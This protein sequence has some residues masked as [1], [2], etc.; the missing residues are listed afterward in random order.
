MDSSRTV[1]ISEKLLQMLLESARRLYPKEMIFLLKGERKKNIV[2]VSEVIVPPLATYGAGFANVPLHMLPTDFSIIGTV[3]SHPS[4]N[5]TP[6]T[7]DLNHMF[8]VILMIAGFPYVNAGNIAVY[9]R[10]GEK[11]TLKIANI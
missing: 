9:N 7:T 11:L 1:L 3:H 5:L 2:K 10:N 8:G 6:S 4:G